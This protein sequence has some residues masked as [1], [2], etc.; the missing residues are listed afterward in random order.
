MSK[1]VLLIDV[2]GVLC[3]YFPGEPEPGYERLSVGPVAVWIN[4][5]HGEWLRQLGDTFELVWATTWEQ[6][7]ADIIA[8]ALGLPVM[9]VIEFTHGATNKTWK[10]AD[11]DEYLGDRSAAWL[12]DELGPDADA[13]AESRQGSTLLI[14]VDG[15]IGMTE[16]H[17]GDLIAFA[18]HA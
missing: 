8:P 12:D 7:A 2:D 4:P 17:V 13:W 14:R 16:E 18:E 5:A 6:E 1:P 11:V 10:I 9:P 3:P 15:T